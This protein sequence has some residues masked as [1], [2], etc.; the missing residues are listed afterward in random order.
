MTN[1]SAAAVRWHPLTVCLGLEVDQLACFRSSSSMGS[2]RMW[3]AT[4]S[5]QEE[6]VSSSL[7]TILCLIHMQHGRQWLEVH[8]GI[9][10]PLAQQVCTL[11]AGH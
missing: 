4:A 9:T 1:R 5:A 11:V 10:I 7:G 2:P 3:L 8:F 6:G